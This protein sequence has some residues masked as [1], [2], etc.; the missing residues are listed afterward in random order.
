MAW[1]KVIVAGVVA[2]VASSVSQGLVWLLSGTPVAETFLR[3][4]R[5]AAALVLGRAVIDQT[6]RWAVILSCATAVHF[7]LSIGFSFAII[8]LV[9]GLTSARAVLAGGLIG[10]FLYVVNLYGLTEVFPWFVVA[11][12]W[13]TAIAHIVFGASAV[14][15]YRITAS[16]GNP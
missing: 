7:V 14:W 15:S 8:S 11:R 3:D 5:L 6:D 10:L 13:S 2:G 4:A 16:R 9:D 12:G 1:Q